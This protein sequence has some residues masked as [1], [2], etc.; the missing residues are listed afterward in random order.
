M[1]RV[2]I[3]TVE[4]TFCDRIFDILPEKYKTAYS[5][6][7]QEQKLNLNEIRLR[8]FMPCSFTVSGSNVQMINPHTKESIVSSTREIEDI[9]HRMCE[10]S[11]YAYSE[12]IKNGYIPFMGTRVGFAGNACV[13][14][15]EIKS[16]VNFTSLNI[17][18]PRYIWDASRE[19]VNY[20]SLKGIENALGVLVVSPPGCGKT[21][22][23]RSLAC[24][25]SDRKSVV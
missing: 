18:V 13:E 17:R 20:I 8:A 21:T 10:G 25:L 24:N 5:I 1:E 16:F 3:R 19:F 4:R 6:L 7:S 2:S 22:F 14:D 15:G 12:H 23:L 11:I 9:V